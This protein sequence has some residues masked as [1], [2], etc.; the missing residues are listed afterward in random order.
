[1]VAGPEDITAGPMEP[2]PAMAGAEPTT[3]AALQPPEASDLRR[4]G[5]NERAYDR[6]HRPGYG[7]PA[8]AASS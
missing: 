6:V 4:V 5:G 2:L 1:M 7:T 8:N 3:D